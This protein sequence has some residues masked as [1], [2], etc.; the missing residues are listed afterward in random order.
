M[1]L[2][3]EGRSLILSIV[4]ISLNRAKA[5]ITISSWHILILD[6]ADKP[7]KIRQ[8]YISD[9]IFNREELSLKLKIIVVS[10]RK[11]WFFLVSFAEAHPLN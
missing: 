3:V 1:F 11:L 7:V 4:N 2:E 10:I 6:V 9:F 5:A 8:I